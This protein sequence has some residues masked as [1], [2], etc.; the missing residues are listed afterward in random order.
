MRS[1]SVMSRDRVSL[2][3]HFDTGSFTESFPSSWR[4]RA[5]AATNC[6]VTEPIEKRVLVST[7]TFGCRDA[8]P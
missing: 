4:S 6:L 1:S 8:E 5:S 3:Y 2:G 7:G